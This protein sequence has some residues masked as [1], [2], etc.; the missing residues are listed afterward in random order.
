MYKTP[1]G[2]TS[3]E[4]AENS[5]LISQIILPKYQLIKK[6]FRIFPTEKNFEYMRQWTIAFF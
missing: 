6:I 2:Q 5:S 4:N 3:G 1:T